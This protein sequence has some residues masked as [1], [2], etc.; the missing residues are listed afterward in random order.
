MI[1]D[2]MKIVT[3]ATCHNRREKTLRALDALNSQEFSADAQLHH[4][5]V[6]DGSTDGTSDAISKIYPAVEIIRGT[7]D[8]FWAG[9]MRY[10]WNFCVKN[11][12][13]D[14]LFLYN[15]DVEL[16]QNAIQKLVEVALS[17]QEANNNRELLVAGSFRNADYQTTYGGLV[18]KNKLH[19]LRFQLVD[20]LESGF[21]AV[22]TI[23]MNGVL[24]SKAT[25]NRAG[26]LA[27]YFIHNGAD[28]EYGLR[29]KRLDIAVLLAPSYIGR[30]DRN[31]KNDHFIENAHSLFDA[32][33]TLVSEK[34][35]PIRQ[36]Y[37][38]Y[39]DYGGPLWVIYLLIPYLALPFKFFL[40]GSKI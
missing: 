6:D 1:N 7:G 12:C 8:L 14:Y 35:H 16:D 26:F 19:P 9:G 33:K 5:I 38:F 20:P 36:R 34:N 40:K 21:R 27:T 22:E 11:K 24:I 17:Y 18:K 39:K 3:L 13:F 23:N 28:F 15:D 4:V 37:I 10:A 30:C 29:L 32:F 25:L 31:N 2:T